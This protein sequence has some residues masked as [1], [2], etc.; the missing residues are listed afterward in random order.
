[1]NKGSAWMPMGQ[2]EKELIEMFRELSPEN[3]ANQL[4]YLRAVYVV[5]KNTRKYIETT[6]AIHRLC[7]QR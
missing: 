4:S 5:E 6:V 2:D 1:M 3:R 7:V